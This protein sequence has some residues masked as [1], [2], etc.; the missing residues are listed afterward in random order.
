[1]IEEL[2]KTRL[3]QARRGAGAGHRDRRPD[4]AALQHPPEAQA[5]EDRARSGLRHGRAAHRHAVGEG[6]LRR[7]RHHPSDV[8]AGAGTH[9]GLHRHA[10]PE[11]L[12]I[13]SHVGH[14]RARGALRGADPHGGH[15]PDRGRRDRRALEIQGRPGRRRAA[16]S[17]ISSGCGSSSNGS[18]RSAIPQE[19]LQN[20]KIE[21]YPEEVYIFTPRGRG[22]GA[23]ARC[24][25]GG[26]RVRDPH[27]RRPPVRRRARQRQD[28]AA[29]RPPAQRRHRR[30][31]HGRR[32][33][34]EPRLAELRRHLARAKQDQALHPLGGEGAQHRARAQ[35]V[36][37][38]GQAVR[39]EPQEP[40]RA[41]DDGA[42]ARAST[43]MGKADELYA[44]LGYGKLS[45]KTVLGQVRP[46]GGAEGGAGRRASP[47]SCAGCSAPA[48]TRSRCTASTT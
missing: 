5:A 39:A 40:D 16:T 10:A 19:F 13:A 26:F 43:G 23:P 46:A 4:Q 18:R 37:Q 42:G 8:V 31:R 35:A 45:A 30:D 7:A 3:G 14:Q 29:P 48:R 11:R 6:L 32:A 27:R 15:A 21:L 12:S 33:Q 41:R 25:A 44:A 2:K 38:G 47:R 36:R 20:L 17:S 22:Q 9:Q 28:G 34:A 1:M 24:D